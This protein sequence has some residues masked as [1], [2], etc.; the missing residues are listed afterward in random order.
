M[1]NK[2]IALALNLGLETV[3]WNLKNIF[4]K[5][6]VT[7]RY[8]A[9]VYVRQHDLGSSG[10]ADKGHPLGATGLAQCYELTHQVRG[11]AEA[12]QVEG[13]KLALQHNLGAAAP[14]WLR[15]TAEADR[16]EQ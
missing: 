7:N 1:A 15:C 16:N 13:V 6:G 11:T 4:R 9:I 14:A 5:L 12:R 3:K 2:R 8:D 10:R